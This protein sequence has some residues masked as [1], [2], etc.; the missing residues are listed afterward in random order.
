MA[1][2]AGTIRWT[3]EMG[4]SEFGIDRKTITKRA[5]TSGIIAGEDGKYSTSDLAA[6]IFGSMHGETLR[7][8]REEADKLA[9]QNQR[10][11]NELVE[12]DLVIKFCNGIGVVLRQK[13][14][15]S[16]MSTDEK[17]ELL[18]E[19]RKLFDAGTVTEQTCS[20]SN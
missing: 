9:L 10:E 2:K 12:A 20:T 19:I 5:K 13:L 6:A 4:S 15:A 17:D 3:L 11:R 18:A 16:S 1:G 14:L 7:K 8:V